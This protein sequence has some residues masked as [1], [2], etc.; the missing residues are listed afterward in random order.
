[1][2][3]NLFSTF[4]QDRIESAIETINRTCDTIAGFR[5]KNTAGM[6]ESLGKFVKSKSSYSSPRFGHA[7]DFML[8]AFL[9]IKNSEKSNESTYL[10]SA[11]NVFES[12]FRVSDQIC[13]LSVTITTNGLT[14]RFMLS[15]A[16]LKSS[17]YR[18]C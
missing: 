7:N 1:M 11:Q 16:T 3:L 10:M 18:R 12:S 5:K 8:F 6:V 17:C 14:L 15:F 2:Y 13:C 4:V 9:A